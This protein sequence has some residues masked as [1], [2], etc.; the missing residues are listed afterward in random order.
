METVDNYIRE[1]P[2]IR[3]LSEKNL[4]YLFCPAS[5]PQFKE[6]RMLREISRFT[7]VPEIIFKK[8]VSIALH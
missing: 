7:L 2:F 3:S 4:C 1:L 6:G 5:T 8:H